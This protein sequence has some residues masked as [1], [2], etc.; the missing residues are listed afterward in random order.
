MAIVPP[1]PH[2]IE[3]YSRPTETDLGEQHDWA[4]QGVQNADSN[5][6]ELPQGS[7]DATQANL[8]SESNAVAYK[9]ELTLLSDDYNSQDADYG[10]EICDAIKSV[11]SSLS[12]LNDL[13]QDVGYLQQ[14]AS[15]NG[16]Q[17][18]NDL[19]SVIEDATRQFEQTFGQCIDDLGVPQWVLEEIQALFCE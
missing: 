12:N 6:V 5:A 3:D 7:L 17:A 4:N 11:Q 9:E 13:N 16:A 14:L 8:Q 1:E 10:S 15:N 19:A 18:P 2:P